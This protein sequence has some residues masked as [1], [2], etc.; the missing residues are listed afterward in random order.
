MMVSLVSLSNV[1][2][3]DNLSPNIIVIISDDA[4]YNDFG[5]YGS[6][7]MRTPNI[8]QLAKSG[9]RFTNG[10]VSASV[11]GPSRAGLMTGRYQQRFG[12]E[13]NNVPYAMDETVGLQGEEM[14]LPLNQ[15]TMA[16]YMKMN[17]YISIAIGKWHL[18]L[19]ERYHP[20][21]RGFDE[22]YGFLGGARHY[23]PNKG[24]YI[25]RE[26]S[27]RRDHVKQANFEY[28][29]DAFTDAAINFIGRN[30]QNPF[31]VYLA[32]NAVHTPLEA[33]EED[34]TDFKNL[35]SK[36]HQTL[37]AMTQSMDENIGQLLDFLDQKNIREN[38]L[39]FFINDNG[40]AAHVMPANNYPL[41]GCKG[42]HYEGGIRVPF[43]VS[44]PA[45]L[46]ASQEYDYPV[47]AFDI[48]ATMLGSAGAKSIEVQPLDGVNLIPYLTGKNEERPHKTLFWREEA[49]AAVRDGDWK[50]LRFP[51]KP[52]ELYNL[53]DDIGES[54]N[55]AAQKPELVQS[56]YAKLW[57]WE[58]ELARPLWF[59]KTKY[60][61][62]VIDL[63]EKFRRK[64]QN[65]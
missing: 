48:L 44:W 40:G 24:D 58:Q 50:L 3:Q 20:L 52:A 29:T 60:D 1:L 47:I 54:N 14:G 27:V 2:S 18:G 8:N 45:L 15:M 65:D 12:Y 49:T 64:S 11:C 55:L 31:F 51:N 57:A 23:F 9:V 32:Y 16:D 30:M 35:K 10:Y 37:A 46:P 33:K 25:G 13:V 62:Q 59:L 56:L 21:E 19:A 53:T 34:L 6:N 61:K 43:I 22:F 17:G 26:K 5:C 63:G 28:T 4:G 7:I 41:S 39:I 42:T 36:D 38:T